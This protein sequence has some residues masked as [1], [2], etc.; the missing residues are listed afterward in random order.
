MGKYEPLSARLA[1]EEGPLWRATF[2]ELEEVLGFSLPK[3]A[4]SGQ[5]WWSNS[6]VEPQQKAWTING[7]EVN[8]L[9]VQGG[10]V[11]FRKM[12]PATNVE[13]RK[14]RSSEAKEPAILTRLDARPK[15]SVA[16]VVGSAALVA[17]VGALAI[18]GLWR[19]R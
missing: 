2:A 12:A 7:W 6:G 8:Q 19:R 1:A 5:S 16:L 11:T 9:D 4:R 14:S 18:R 13:T 10:Q 17:G 15:W 3:R